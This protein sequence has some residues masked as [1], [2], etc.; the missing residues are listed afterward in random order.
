METNGE[1][2]ALKTPGWRNG[3]S[4][5]AFGKRRD[6]NEEKLIERLVRR[7]PEPSPQNENSRETSEGGPI[8]RHFNVASRSANRLRKKG[9]TKKRQATATPI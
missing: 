3:T 9:K 5:A 1:K 2:D 6:G 8:L 4:T 7:T